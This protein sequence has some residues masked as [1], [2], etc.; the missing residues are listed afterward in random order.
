MKSRRESL[1]VSIAES[2]ESHAAD[3]HA[4]A[5]GAMSRGETALAASYSRR[6]VECYREAREWRREFER[7]VTGRRDT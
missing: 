7:L 1:I 6:A 3:W 4:L 2:Y 5:H